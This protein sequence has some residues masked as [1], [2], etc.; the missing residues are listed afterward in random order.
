MT[1]WALSDVMAQSLQPAGGSNDGE[2][3]KFNQKLVD[4][5]KYCKEVLISIRNANGGTEGSDTGTL[6]STVASNA[7]ATGGVASKLAV[8]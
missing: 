5:L 2:A 8:R 3:A 4:K 1:R 6:G 7:G